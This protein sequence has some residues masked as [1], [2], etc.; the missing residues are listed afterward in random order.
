MK[1]IHNAKWFIAGVIFT[2]IA[3]IGITALATTGQRNATITYRDIKVLLNGSQVSLSSEPFLMDGTTYLPLRAIGNALGLGVDWD[4]NTS[5][6]KL[7]SG[8]SGGGASPTAPPTA[9]DKYS[10]TNPAPVGTAQTIVID[11]YSGKYTATITVVEALRGDLAW[12]QIKA[13]NQFNNLPADG[14]EYILVKVKATIESTAEDKSV[15]FYNGSLTAYSSSNVEY[16]S[17]GVVV[18]KPALSGNVFAGGTLEGY[19]AF[20]VDKTDSAPK[21]V[22]GENYDGSG[23]IWFALN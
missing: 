5:T 7:T 18:P 23:G 19:V 6:V 14:K 22:Y 16:K 21:T 13:A 1:K 15:S 2:L 17:A 12:Q 8:S 10:R 11:S 20:T 3:S 4:G 9:S